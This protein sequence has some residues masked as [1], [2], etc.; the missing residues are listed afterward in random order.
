MSSYANDNVYLSDTAENQTYL[1][2]NNAMNISN[3]VGGFCNGIPTMSVEGGFA[4][5]VCALAPMDGGSIS[6]TESYAPVF[7]TC[8]KSSSSSTKLWTCC[9]CGDG[10]MSV[11]IVASCTNYN[12]QHQRCSNCVVYKGRAN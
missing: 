1:E 4:V 11:K 2:A 10:P 6:A 7:T 3:I 9:H 8:G 5:T 12:C